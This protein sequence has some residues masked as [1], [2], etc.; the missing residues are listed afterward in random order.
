[1]GEAPPDKT[2]LGTGLSD[3]SWSSSSPESAPSDEDYIPSEGS[4]DVNLT[5]DPPYTTLRREPATAK[6][7]TTTTT[8]DSE[9]DII[10]DKISKEDTPESPEVALPPTPRPPS[11][12]TTYTVEVT[13]NQ[14]TDV[15]VDRF[16]K[17][18]EEQ[19][20]LLAQALEIQSQL[21]SHA[22]TLSPT[23]IVPTP[24]STGI[25]STIPSTNISTSDRNI[26]T[27]NV[28]VHL[29]VG[30][31]PTAVTIAPA[32]TLI[33]TNSSQNTS[34]AENIQQYSARGFK[35]RNTQE[36]GATESVTP[37]QKLAAIEAASTLKRALPAPVANNTTRDVPQPLAIESKPQI[38]LALH[39]PRDTPDETSTTLRNPHD[40]P[41]AQVEPVTS[42]VAL[43]HPSYAPTFTSSS[44]A[45]YPSPSETSSHSLLVY[46]LPANANSMVTSTKYPSFLQPIPL[47]LNT[48]LQGIS[49]LA[50]ACT[51]P[52]T[53]K[54]AQAHPESSEWKEACLRE[55][56]AFQDHKTY[57]LMPLPEG[58]KPL[59]SRWLFSI[60]STG[61]KKARLVAQ[62]YTQQEGIDYTETFAPVVR[63]DSVRLFLALSDC[64]R[65]PIHQMDVNTAFL[66]YSNPLCSD[67]LFCHLNWYCCPQ[68]H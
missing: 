8:E 6:S 32:N 3:N 2:N 59:G 35:R 62:G 30:I 33:S 5:D 39:P 57:E 41:L 22:P 12:E 50:N 36:P 64:L 37:P 17:I 43:P 20:R 42:F 45:I 1:M 67:S 27:N 56:K 15:A 29:P 52:K 34:S 11:P 61:L 55:L 66:N 58:R 63:Y 53:L 44:V 60:K 18:I 49:P 16:V 47:N 19:N 14:S 31:K 4:S 46:D 51:V 21:T 9:I 13:E 48:V 26:P 65:L 7:D 25:P 24:T 68:S 40:R 10:E 23:S 38:H 54:Q 28:V